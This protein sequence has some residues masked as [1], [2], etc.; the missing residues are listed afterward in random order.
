M[1]KLHLK[2]NDKITLKVP[3]T[4]DA[5][6]VFELVEKNRKH[7]ETFMEWESKTNSLQDI[8]DYFERNKHL[9]YYDSDFPLI[10]RYEN[11]IVGIVGYNKGNAFQK[12][13]DIGYWISKDFTQRGIVTK[14]CQALIN[15]AFSMTDIEKIYIKCEITNSRSYAIAMKLGFEFVEQ[16]K[17]GCYLKNGNAEM[18]SFELRKPEIL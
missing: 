9:S 14:C 15:F 7:L 16:V 6:S 8:L 18:I 2:V 5:L 1:I 11:E 17:G 12:T 13:V 4:E 10:I 3:E